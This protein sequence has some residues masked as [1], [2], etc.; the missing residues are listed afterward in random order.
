M[1]VAE[2]V[3]EAKTE[4]ETLL[5]VEQTWEAE[6]TLGTWRLVSL[7]I[8]S[9]SGAY[10][11]DPTAEDFTIVCPL[12]CEFRPK[13]FEDMAANSNKSTTLGACLKFSKSLQ[14]AVATHLSEVHNTPKKT[15]EGVDELRHLEQSCEHLGAENPADRRA[16]CDYL[17][18]KYT[19]AERTVGVQFG[20]K[21]VI[22]PRGECL[23]QMCSE[24]VLLPIETKADE[25]VDNAVPICGASKS[26][27]SLSKFEFSQNVKGETLDKK[28]VCKAFV[29]ALGADAE[30]HA[31]THSGSPSREVVDAK[32]KEV[33][34]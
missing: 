13:E 12:K 20:T 22:K 34:G 31:Q 25:L 4:D 29:K 23:L 32:Y 26:D 5:E 16:A 24:F 30:K 17:I 8:L 18:L 33:I 21:V 14:E 9:L 11:S 10:Y 1:I 28:R 6:V 2:S 15:R 19:S 3:F 7:R 27:C